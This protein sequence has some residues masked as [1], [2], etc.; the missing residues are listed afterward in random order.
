[1]TKFFA[2]ILFWMQQLTPSQESWECLHHKYMDTDL[3]DT[4]K[5]ALDCMTEK[6]Y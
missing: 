5:L 2:L 3:A 1:M 4:S 6:G